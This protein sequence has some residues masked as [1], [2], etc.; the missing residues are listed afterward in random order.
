[1]L[2]QFV[3]SF[4]RRTLRHLRRSSESGSLGSPLPTSGLS[5]AAMSAATDPAIQSRVKQLVEGDT[6]KLFDVAADS[7]ERKN[8]IKDPQCA[9]DVKQLTQKL[10]THMQRTDDPQLKAFETAIAN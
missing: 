3:C 7:N 6:L 9:S 1:M 2:A 5:F 10:L 8:L 4:M